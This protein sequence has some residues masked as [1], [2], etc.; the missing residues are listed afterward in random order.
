MA[1]GVFSINRIARIG[2]WGTENVP[3]PQR[4]FIGV[5]LGSVLFGAGVMTQ[6]MGPGVAVPLAQAL[7]H[8][9]A[10][11]M[12]AK[13][14]AI[15]GGLAGLVPGFFG[16]TKLCEACLDYQ[17]DRRE[18]KKPAIMARAAAIAPEGPAMTFSETMG[19]DFARVTRDARTDAS[20]APA[21]QPA[22]APKPS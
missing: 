17:H 12:V 16:L 7:L 13:P 10:A 18:E 2:D 14:L 4:K 21:S 11:A 8:L 20:A 5:A 22:K 15:L 9:P 19:S 6:I 1:G 3:S